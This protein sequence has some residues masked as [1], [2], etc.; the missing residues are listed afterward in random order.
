MSEQEGLVTDV[1]DDEREPLT[2]DVL[3]TIYRALTG[4]EPEGTVQH[5]EIATLAQ[6]LRDEVTSMHRRAQALEGIEA[7]MRRLRLT[8]AKQMA[9]RMVEA[10]QTKRMW[11]RHYRDGV[12]QIIDAGVDDRIDG[13]DFRRTGYLSEMIRRLV[14]ERDKVVFELDMRSSGLEVEKVK[15]R[16]IE[17]LKA[18]LLQARKQRD[19]LCRSMTHS[20]TFRPYEHHDECGGLFSGCH[21]CAK[22]TLTIEDGPEDWQSRAERLEKECNDARV[23]LKEVLH[24]FHDE[25]H[26]GREWASVYERIEKWMESWK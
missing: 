4:K 24:L 9:D 3:S 21:G 16:E 19:A 22:L 5:S 12:Q 13:D 1:S 2:E 25:N 17:R 11:Q 15:D 8:H 6:K 23:L 7:R 20:L 18:D 10:D 26:A 14:A